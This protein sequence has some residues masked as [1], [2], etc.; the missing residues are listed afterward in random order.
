MGRILRFRG[1]TTGDTQQANILWFTVGARLYK[2]RVVAPRQT[3][4][5]G[6]LLWHLLGCLGNSEDGI[7]SEND[8]RQ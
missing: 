7:L 4:C 8:N 6:V 1:N 2:D 3:V 5:G